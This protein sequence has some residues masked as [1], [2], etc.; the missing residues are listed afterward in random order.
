MYVSTT[1][2]RRAAARAPVR[3]CCLCVRGERECKGGDA[4]LAGFGSPTLIPR[5][6][7]VARG[8]ETPPEQLRRRLLLGPRACGG[9]NSAGPLEEGSLAG[10]ERCLGLFSRLRGRRRANLE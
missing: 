8:A 4:P 6:A 1:A 7:G 10:A 9:A 2:P 3:A 5:G